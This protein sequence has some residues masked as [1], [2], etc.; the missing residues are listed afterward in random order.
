MRVR[1]T[2]IAHALRVARNEMYKHV[3]NDDKSSAI[4]CYVAMCFINFSFFSDAYNEAIRTNKEN[5]NEMQIGALKGKMYAW[6]DAWKLAIK[7]NEC[8]T[9]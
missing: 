8:Q 4:N 9:K 1:K 6:R 2:S 7:L 3:L 5:Q